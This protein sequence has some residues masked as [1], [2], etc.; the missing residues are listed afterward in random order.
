MSE[1]SPAHQPQRTEIGSVTPEVIECPSCG[2]YLGVI[3]VRASTSASMPPEDQQL[4]RMPAKGHTFDLA[5]PGQTVGESVKQ[6]DAPTSQVAVLEKKYEDINRRESQADL[7]L[8]TFA[9]KY[10]KGA[11]KRRKAK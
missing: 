1:R 8:I 9:S 4:D 7:V 2:I 5:P 10:R 11:P 3:T 6:E